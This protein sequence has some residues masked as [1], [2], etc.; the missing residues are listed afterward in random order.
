[1]KV[2]TYEKIK[3]ALLKLFTSMHGNNIPINGPIYI[4]KALEFA[5]AFNYGDF[6]ASNEKLRGWKER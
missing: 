4:E 6:K 3:D 5:E 1:M 2:G